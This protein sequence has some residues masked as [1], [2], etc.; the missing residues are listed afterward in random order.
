MNPFK[1]NRRHFKHFLTLILIASPLCGM[2]AYGDMDPA[3]CE[4]SGVINKIKAKTNP[5]D[6]WVRMYVDAGQAIKLHTEGHHE[7]QIATVEDCEIYYQ[8]NSEKLQKCI[9]RIENTIDYWVKCREHARRM[10][11]LHKGYCK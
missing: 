6:F 5:L 10:C 9:W 11:L 7:M 4:P 8:R 3:T 1:K 2:A